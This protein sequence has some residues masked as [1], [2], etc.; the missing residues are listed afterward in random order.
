M[1]TLRGDATERIEDPDGVN[2]A[3]WSTSDQQQ[4]HWSRQCCI[5]VTREMGRDGIPSSTEQCGVEI[6]GVDENAV[7]RELEKHIAS[8]HFPEFR[9]ERGDRVCNCNGITKDGKI[10]SRVL[11]LHSEDLPCYALAEHIGKSVAHFGLYV[12]FC[13]IVGH[14]CKGEFASP[15]ALRRHYEKTDERLFRLG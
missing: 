1:A 6:R 3:R 12:R 7:K 4:K 9:Q 8:S 11:K 13:E 10:C 5:A 15:D 14:G 2:A